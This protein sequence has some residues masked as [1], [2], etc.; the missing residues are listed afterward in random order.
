MDAYAPTWYTAAPAIHLMILDQAEKHPEI[1][2]RNSL[3]F[4]RSAS[5]G[6]PPQLK[7]RIEELFKVPQIEAYGMTE[8]APQIASNRIEE[9][10]RRAGSVGRAAGPDIAIMDDA[11]RMLSPLS[12]GEVVVRGANVTQGYLDDPSANE[13][14]FHDG[15][16]RTGDEGY[17]DPD[18]FLFITGR[19]KK[20]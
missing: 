5:S 1:D 16:F 18:G 10:G 2:Y 15:W 17:L 11:G 13:A 20:S 9:N 8:T 4:V 19:I 12:K 3:R 6:M 14:A 7:S